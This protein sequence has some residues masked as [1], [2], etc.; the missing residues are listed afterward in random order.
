M[1]NAPKT[2]ARD[3]A[4]R[5]ALRP[6][7]SMA[8]NPGLAPPE[9]LPRNTWDHGL[10]RLTFI[11]SGGTERL[12]VSAVLGFAQKDAGASVQRRLVKKDH[13]GNAFELRAVGSDEVLAVVHQLN[14]SLAAT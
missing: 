12:T 6:P 13:R 7:A 14:I 3:Y 1:F 8:R 9:T 2:N 5:Q 10:T 4:I 11:P